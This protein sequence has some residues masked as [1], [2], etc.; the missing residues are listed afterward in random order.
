MWPNN[1]QGWITL[2][3]SAIALVGTLTTVVHK[4]LKGYQETLLEVIEKLDEATGLLAEQREINEKQEEAV[5]VSINDRGELR[6]M[7]KHLTIAQQT[8]MQIEIEKIAE[9]S[10]NHGYITSRDKTVLEPL[11]KAYNIEN[12]WNHIEAGKVNTALA[13][14]VKS[15]EHIKE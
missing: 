12:E 11:W 2:I 9:K 4:L 15:D 6:E 10:L 8:Q 3:A 13:L 5:A 1:V 7:I 14:P